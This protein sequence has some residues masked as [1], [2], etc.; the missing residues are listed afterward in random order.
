M[1]LIIM[2]MLLCACSNDEHY[3]QGQ[4]Q[5]IYN[6]PLPP[7]ITTDDLI[8]TIGKYAKDKYEDECI[9]EVYYYCPPLDEVHR[10]KAVVDTCRENKVLSI[11]D[12]EEVLECIPT[13]DIIEVKECVAENGMIGFQ[14]VYCYKGFYEYG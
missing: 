13:L 2:V 8:D 1:P 6:I 3:G 5:S 11:S 12:C 4:G 7:L 10:A 9:R 14:N